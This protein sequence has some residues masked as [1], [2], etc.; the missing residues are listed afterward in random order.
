MKLEIK[1]YTKEIKN[2][3]I[4]NNINLVLQSGKVYG[5]YGRNGSGK[6]ML[7]RAVT[8]LIKPTSGDV[9]IDDQ[10]II[11]ND[12]DLSQIGILIEDPGYYPHLSGA[13]NLT[14]LYTINHKRDDAYIMKVLERVNLGH[15][16]NKKYK[17]YSLGMKQRL[18]VAQAFME[19]QKLIILD[20]PTN[21]IDEEGLEIVYKLIEETKKDDCL[22]LMASHNKEDLLNLCDVVYKIEDGKIVGTIEKGDQSDK[23]IKN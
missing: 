7:F 22:I 19:N 12:F 21:G 23:E 4:L 11:E 9:L 13:E 8:T 14:M 3:I 5:F 15:A 17:E 1:N 10:S 20:E 6:T 2:N 18:R 16:A